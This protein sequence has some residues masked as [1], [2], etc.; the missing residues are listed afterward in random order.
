MRKEKRR[1]T[2]RE[3]DETRSETTAA[4]NNIYMTFNEKCLCK[5]LSWQLIET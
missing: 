4:E 2:K 1:D 5:L 3:R